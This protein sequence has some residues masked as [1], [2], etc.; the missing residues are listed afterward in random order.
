MKS[1]DDVVEKLL[2]NF[3]SVSC[4]LNVSREEFQE[5]AG[6]LEEVGE[7]LCRYNQWYLD[8]LSI[9]NDNSYLIYNRNFSLLGSGLSGILPAINEF[10]YEY[11]SPIGYTFSISLDC[12]EC[13]NTLDEFNVTTNERA[14][15]NHILLRYD[16]SGSVSSTE[17]A[18]LIRNLLER[19]IAVDWIGPVRPLLESGILGDD[20][21]NSRHLT[22]YPQHKTVYRE[23]TTCTPCA[24]MLNI[25]I[26]GDGDI[27]PCFPLVGHELARIGCI[28]DEMNSIFRKELSP[29]LLHQWMHSGPRLNMD[30]EV[31][32]EK[33]FRKQ[34]Q[35]HGKE[36]MFG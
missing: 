15:I 24:S 29:S 18:Q 35:L 36:F 13:I 19:K 2:A 21:V 14:R 8:R 4:I 34:C 30:A 32:A 20:A 1:N 10:I 7:W 25:F 22:I 6:F 28:H 17:L 12:L 11:I 26:N 9:S 5:S 31:I 3:R 33:K 27:Y 23:E 16:K